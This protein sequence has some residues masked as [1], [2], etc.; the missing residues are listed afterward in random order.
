MIKHTY[1]CDRCVIEGESVPETDTRTI[2]LCPV[3]RSRMSYQLSEDISDETGKVTSRWVDEERQKLHPEIKNIQPH[4]PTITC[5]YCKSTDCKKITAT[6]K[7]VNI[8]LF[9]IF[10]NKRRHQWHCQKCG[11]DF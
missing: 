7:A 10:G 2:Y 6:A 8:A 9:G 5:P 4:K 11:S 3:C 1:M